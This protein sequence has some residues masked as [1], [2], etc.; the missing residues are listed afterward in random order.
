M[1]KRLNLGLSLEN[2]KMRDS[3]Y[4]LLT[5]PFDTAL[6]GGTGLHS[7]SDTKTMKQKKIAPILKVSFLIL[8]QVRVM[9]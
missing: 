7:M 4:Y 8:V 6:A 5:I 3:S 9:K 1:A 2:S